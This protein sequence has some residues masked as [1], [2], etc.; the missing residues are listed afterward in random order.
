[1]QFKFRHYIMYREP[2]TGYMNSNSIYKA[3]KAKGMKPVCDHSN[4]QD[5]KCKAI[6]GTWHFSHPSHNRSHKVDV[7]KVQYAF[8]YCGK[9]NRQRS[10]L[11]TGRSHKWTHDNRERDGDTFCAKRDAEFMKKHGT[12]KHNNQILKRVA[13]NGRI[14]SES[15]YAA[16]IQKKM[17]PVCDHPN[18]FDGRC[19]VVNGNR[20]MSREDKVKGT[21]EA[22]FY[23]GRANGNKALQHM[24]GKH[25]WSNKKDNAGETI[26]TKPTRAQGNFK[27]RHYSL[28]RTQVVGYMSSGNIRKACQKKSMKPLC[29]HM[30]YNDGLCKAIGGNWHFSHP[31][32]DKS[33]KVD[34]NKVK[35]AFFYC[36]RANHQRSLIN[37]GR[38]H[39]WTHTNRERDGDSYCVTRDKD[40]MKKHGTFKHNNFLLKRVQVPGIVNSKSIFAACQKKGLRPVCDHQTYFDGRCIV[41]TGRKHMSRKDNLKGVSDAYFYCGRANGNKALQHM[42]GRHRWSNGRDRD[43]ETICTKPSGKIIFTYRSYKLHRMRVSGYMTSSNIYSACQRKNMKPVCDNSNYQDG[44]CKAVG[45]RWHFS[46][47]HHD[48]QHKID[49]GLVKWAFFYCGR[50]NGDKALLNTGRTHKWTRNKFERD[51]DTF[52]AKR[53]KDFL[54]KHGSFKHA[55]YTLKRVHVPGKLTSQTIYA[56]CT[57]KKMIPVCDHASYF[58]GRCEV[59]G[60]HKH[61]S[62]DDKTKG[63]QEAYFY[64]GKTNGNKALQHMHGRHRWSN[65]NDKNGETIC[66]KRQKY[67]KFKFRSYE[68]HRTPVN[69]YM[70]SQNMFKACQAKGMQP[71]CDHRNYNDGKC[72]VSG[73]N[74]HFSHPSHDRRYKID[75][76]KVKWA[77]FYCGRANGNKALL[78]TGRTHKWTTNNR[79]RDGD[80]FCAKRDP[81]FSKDHGSFTLHGY[82]VKRVPVAGKI[83]SSSIFN[84]CNKAAMKPVC[85]HASYFDGRCQVVNGNKHVTRQ[86]KIKGIWDAYVYCGRSNHNRALQHMHSGHRWSNSHDQDGETLCTKQKP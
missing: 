60:G 80:T 78:N 22:F 67:T 85:D 53:D 49:V 2:V 23:C 21:W 12:F 44:K 76:N 84:A 43:G 25:R 51:G 48:R 66:T 45:G 77:F 27:Y 71:L 42:V 8:F 55:K 13:V 17:R 30:S 82:R 24:H 36:G 69:G 79:E 33:H 28:H 3:C 64:C 57:A 34:V 70:T 9:A 26:C 47:P 37:T 20:H 16:C 68:L 75:V 52:C 39:K 83:N 10:L 19:I 1:M 46:H 6:G 32:H 18:Y 15:I 73:G 50:A 86:R 40:F 61:M 7:K 41:V 56:A 62:R 81:Q 63:V 31:S 35:W 74:W 65:S 58:D 5:G 54:K 11:N 29:D 38:T 4:Y 72:K 14:S 59:V